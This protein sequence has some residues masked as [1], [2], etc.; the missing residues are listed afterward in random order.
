MPETT[1]PFIDRNFRNQISGIPD[2]EEHL[3]QYQSENQY[4][5][6][7]STQMLQ[8]ECVTAEKIE[9]GA[10]TATE[11]S[12][13]AF[14]VDVDDLDDVDDGSTY[15][16]VK[17]TDITSGHIVLSTTSGDLDDISD[18]SNYGKV[19]VNDISSGH[20][21]L[22]TTSGDLDDISDGSTY[23]KVAGTSI[24]AG[25]IIVAGLDSG[26]TA[27]MFTNSTTQTNMEG[28]IHGSDVTK[29]DGGDIYANTITATQI[30]AGTITA[31]EINAG[32]ITATEIDTN[33]RSI[34]RL[35]NSVDN[36]LYGLTVANNVGIG[37]GV[38]PLITGTPPNNGVN[39]VAFG[40]QVL[41]AC[42]G[43][44]GN[45]AM[46]YQAM[47]DNTVGTENIAIGSYALD[48]NVAG[49]QQV[50]IGNGA[51][52]NVLF[53]SETNAN[54]VAIG[55]GAGGNL[56]SGT[57][58]VFLG[59]SAGINET[60]SN[61][62]Y[63]ANS[64][65]ATPLIKGVFPNTSLTFTST[66]TTFSG[67][68]AW[69]SGS[70]A[71]ANTAYAHSQNN[72][73]AHTDYLINNGDDVFAGTLQIAS[74]NFV[75]SLYSATDNVWGYNAKGHLSDSSKLK[76][77]SGHASIHPQAIILGQAGGIRFLTMSSNPGADADIVI[78]TY[79]RMRIDTSGNLTLFSATSTITGGTALY[80]EAGAT[81]I[82]SITIKN[83]TTASS[84]NQY[85]NPTTGK[86]WRENSS[87]RFKENIEEIELGSSK[88]HQLRP[89]SFDTIHKNTQDHADEGKRFVGLI[90]ED[91]EEIYPELID[92]NEKN[93]AENYDTRML[94]TLMLAEIQN[95]NGR[96]KS[97]EQ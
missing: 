32:T 66:T 92:Y 44:D 86:M 10:I 97:L 75:S 27:R 62:L 39:N 54:N 11:I 33:T 5:V 85:I 1:T 23:G 78:A 12:F 88:L 59:Y 68:V 25:K 17:T 21:L 51:L 15:S 55:H 80:I 47:H 70:S 50:A 38:F 81:G 94:M 8:A 35:E 34:D 79:E 46:G 18:G 14:D 63:I 90:A 64:N 72:S 42:T 96:I 19:D 69:S 7:I 58:C 16:R 71:N 26:V 48:R 53:G 83:D 65:T 36:A 84:A 20:I 41:A 87:V 3:Y 30:A 67:T 82:G 31:T 57:G 45:I 9:A 91:V 60:G 52:G 61:F 2:I 22:S 40:F 4:S 28:W 74:Y 73:Q 49:H 37:E 24:T 93:E 6:S 76:S 77:I 95:L 13:T 29:I 89:V 43:G 56:A